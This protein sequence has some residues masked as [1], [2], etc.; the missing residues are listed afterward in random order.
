MTRPQLTLPEALKY[1][2]HA[3]VSDPI[4]L[5]GIRGY[6][7]K[8]MGD[9]AKNDRGIYDDAMFLITPFIYRSYNANTDPSVTRKGVAVLQP[10]VYW[11]IKGLHNIS[12]LNRKNKKHDD[13]YRRLMATGKDVKSWPR[14]YWALRQDS[15]AT[16]MRDDFDTPMTDDAD[17]RFWIN[18]HKG[19]Y[20]TT[21]S[22][23]CQTI[24]P[25]QW[26][27]FRENIY[28]EMARTGQKRVPYI[29]MAND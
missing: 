13:I 5:L 25:D 8:T 24:Y 11:Y 29:L 6:Y 28:S 3:G 2:E 26:E 22:L 12:K 20:N 14:T 7:K 9:P 23:G 16:V 15:D 27:E 19:S 10:G 18:I 1:C 4:K 21:S 17:A